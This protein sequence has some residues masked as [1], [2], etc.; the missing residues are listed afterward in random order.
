MI[1]P[2]PCPTIQVTVISPQALSYAEMTSLTEIQG[3]RCRILDIKATAT[4]W[5][6]IYRYMSSIALFGTGA[7]SIITAI[8]RTAVSVE[9]Y[10]QIAQWLS[11]I[12]SISTILMVKY[13]FEH[14]ALVYKQMGSLCDEVVIEIDRCK[15]K[16]QDM[17][18][19]PPTD[20]FNRVSHEIMESLN[21]IGVAADK[22]NIDCASQADFVAFRSSFV[23]QAT[24]LYSPKVGGIDAGLVNPSD[25]GDFPPIA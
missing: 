11:I 20:D 18:T 7:P 17:Y 22:L 9:T 25:I 3:L 5:A 8:T 12:V 15:A 14:Y 10:A 1:T 4:K 24:I 23:A 21:I 2:L 6:R 16:L 19:R 13:S